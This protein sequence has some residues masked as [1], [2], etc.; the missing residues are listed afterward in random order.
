[1]VPQVVQD[2]ERHV[3]SPKNHVQDHARRR[4]FVT[5]I[6]QSHPCFVPA[7]CVVHVARS[8]SQQTTYRR[9][10]T[11]LPVAPQKV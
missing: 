8:P 4:S 7:A 11:A 2:R 9:Q 1:M 3:R 5:V 10:G 6:T